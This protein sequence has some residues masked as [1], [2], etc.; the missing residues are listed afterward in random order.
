MEKLPLSGLEVFLAVAEHGSLRLA[1]ER[2]G[3]QPPAVSYQLKMLEKRVGTALFARTT[4]SVTLTDAG[5][6]LLVRARPA[7]IELGGALEDARVR[8]SAHSGHLRLTLPYAA[9]QLG[10]RKRLMSFQARYP[11]IVVELSFNEAFV[12]VVQEGFHAGIRLGDHLNPEMIAVRLTAGMKEAVFA[13]PAYLREHGRPRRPEDL[14]RHNCI[15]YRY[16]ASHRFAQ[17]QFVVDGGLTSIDVSGNLVVN[18]TEAVVAAVR[19]GMGIGWL[20]RP[21][22]AADIRDGNLESVL[23]RYAVER[24]GYFLYYPKASAGIEALRLFVDV[25]RM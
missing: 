6:A 8:G 22:I 21:L 12:D 14:L 23:T 18:S 11:N 1:S 10:I 24:P 17:W 4:R 20:F 25:M 3:V 7:M 13:A 19:A 16:I 15:R 9:F 5:R 2:L